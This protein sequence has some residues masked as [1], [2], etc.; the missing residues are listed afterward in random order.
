MVDAARQLA[1]KRVVAYERA[2]RIVLSK[3][4]DEVIRLQAQILLEAAEA[5]SA[6]GSPVARGVLAEQG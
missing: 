3:Y 1:I 6:P 2:K 4:K 5:A